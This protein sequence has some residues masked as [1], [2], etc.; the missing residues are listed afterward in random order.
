MA[1]RAPKRVRYPGPVTSLR[2]CWARRL[3]RAV[4]L[5]PAVLLVTAAAPALADPPAAWP[6]PPSVSLLHVLL[7]LVVIPAALFAIITLLV[8]VPSMS[9][10]EKYQPG[11]AWH[12]R[13]EWFGGPR[14]GADGLAATERAGVPAEQ[15]RPRGTGGAHAQW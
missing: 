7:V 6:Q 2:A 9:R 8:Y 15:S 14:G 3:A 4:A 13:P 1:S 5:A 10:G 12:A 11:R